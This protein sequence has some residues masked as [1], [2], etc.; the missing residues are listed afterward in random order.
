MCERRVS[1]L[2]PQEYL[3]HPLMI[4]TFIPNVGP[5]GNENIVHIKT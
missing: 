5:I 2:I 4:L 1:F 3:A